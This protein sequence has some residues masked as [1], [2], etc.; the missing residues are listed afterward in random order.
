MGKVIGIFS[1]K[2]GVGKTII[3]S[4]LG[5][6]FGIG[7]RKQTILLDLNAGLGCVDLLLDLNPE[8]NWLDLLPV[9]DELQFSHLKK[10]LTPYDQFLS[11]LS[12]PVQMGW[13]PDLKQSDL[14]SL[15]HFLKDKYDLVLVDTSPGGGRVNQWLLT[16]ADIRLLVLSP[17][18]PALRA[19]QRFLKAFPETAHPVYYVVNQYASG[20]AVSPEAVEKYL[21]GKV[22]S[23]LPI[24]PV[25]VWSNV[26]FGRPCVLDKKSKL[27]GSL[28]KLCQKLLILNT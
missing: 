20:A 16:L 3:L 24:D 6:C 25:G 19:S 28:R 18:G 9:I 7:H 10:C 27:G 8:K 12:C 4:N 23:V 26:S 21:G 17:D 22:A 14:S 2:G 13:E 1:A 11:L 5:V 15:V